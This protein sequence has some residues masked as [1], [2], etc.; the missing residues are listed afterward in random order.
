MVLPA[1]KVAEYPIQDLRASVLEDGLIRAFQVSE[2]GREATIMY[3]YEGEWIGALPGLAPRPVVF[4]QPLLTSTVLRL[5][6]KYARELFEVEG[7]VSRAM[8]VYTATIL[9]RVARVV[10]VRTLGSVNQ[11]IAFDLLERACA[12]QLR[13]GG[14]VIAVTHEELANA[15]GS[16]REV[17]TRSLAALKR[18]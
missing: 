13:S 11:R 2:D 18:A 10:T 5:D 1:G 17:V 12:A 7:G 15:V 8:A 9:A 16:A 3:V 4:A 14:L 6:P